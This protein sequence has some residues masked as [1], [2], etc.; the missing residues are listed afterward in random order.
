MSIIANDYS[1][2]RS[3]YAFEGPPER[4]VQIHLAGFAAEELLS[5]R[6][7]RQLRGLELGMSVMAAVNPLL[8]GAASPA[9][10]SD[11][12]LAVREILTMGCAPNRDSIRAEF[13]HFYAIARA[14]VESVWPAVVAVA[15]ALLERC[16]L[17]R[18]AFSEAVGAHDIYAPVAAVQKAYG[19]R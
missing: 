5:G 1:L 13:E 8:A 17:G 15:Q 6:Q 12:H 3:R 19:L 7:S 9:E 2:G 10:G 16:E 18:D 14:A 11:Q 4:L